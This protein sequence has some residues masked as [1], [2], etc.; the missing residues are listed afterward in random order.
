MLEN[1]KQNNKI[2]YEFNLCDSIKKKKKIGP[3]FLRPLI[4]YFVCCSE[5]S[6]FL[7][8]RQSF[9]LLNLLHYSAHLFE[10]K[11]NFKS[12]LMMNRILEIHFINTYLN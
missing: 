4:K 12:D 11:L 8:S 1:V 10:R 9:S 3:G 2:K 5:I 7:W 6:V